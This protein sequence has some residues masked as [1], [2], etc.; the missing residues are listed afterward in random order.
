MLK[1][2][3]IENFALIDHVSIS[4]NEGFSVITG[5]TGS[6]KSILLNALGLIL[7]ERANFSII[8]NRNNKSVVEAVVNIANFNQKS[9]FEINDL[10]YQEETI[11]RRE[12]LKSGKSR[13]FI[14]DTPVGISVLKSFSTQLIYIHSQNNTQELKD[15]DFQMTIIDVLSDSTK[16]QKKYEELFGTFKKKRI[17]LNELV[18]K[19]SEL[20]K[21]QDFNQFQLAEL[22][23]LNLDNTSFE[24]L[25]SQLEKADNA[26]GLKNAFG[27]VSTVLDSDNGVISSI[28]ALV[29][30]VSR[31]E[32]FD[33]NLAELSR[34]L[35]E[36][37]IELKDITEESGQ[38][39]EGY[40]EVGVDQN[41]L[42]QKLD[43]YNSALLKHRLKTQDELIQLKESLES[44]SLQTDDLKA[45]IIGLQDEINLIQNQLAEIATDLHSKRLQKVSGIASKI[46][47]K[48]DYLKLENTKVIFELSKNEELGKFGYSDLKFLFAP[49]KGVPPSVVHQSASGGELSR[50]M[51]AI[52][53][54]ISDKVQLQTVLFDE[55]DTGVSGGVASKMGSLLKQIGADMQVIAITH[56][57][58]VASKGSQ[59]FKVSKMEVKGVTTS[60]VLELNHEER[61]TEVASLM[62][63]E[64]VNSAAKET[65]LE[66]LNDEL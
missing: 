26:E 43:K 13:A 35:K 46:E 48:L 57:P 50:L 11:I 52:Q 34:R 65:A 8:G 33:V 61:I 66:M 23:E 47:A 38:Q 49:N 15:M 51:L 64:E 25:Q 16:L 60:A 19:E 27:D 44:Y 32:Q 55:I 21:K 29:S 9:F 41:E 40:S 39:I 37:S 63:G 1:K 12:I 4:F 14:N 10:D 3:E 28:N 59:H 30:N 6:G 62:S 20:S 53:S 36:V 7:G 56:L 31:F 42:L 18:L 54:L 22:I 2:L 58:Q 24:N 17:R 5:E 45:H